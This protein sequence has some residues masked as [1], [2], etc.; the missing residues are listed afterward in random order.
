MGLLLWADNVEGV[1]S[2]NHAELQNYRYNI[3]YIFFVLE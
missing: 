1:T 3:F 2:K